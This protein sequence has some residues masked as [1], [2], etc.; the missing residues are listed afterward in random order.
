MNSGV[1]IAILDDVVKFLFRCKKGLNPA[2]GLIGI[3]ENITSN[4]ENIFDEEDSSYTRCLPSILTLVK[5]AGL[6]VIQQQDQTDFPDSIY[7]VKM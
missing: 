6:T 5:K 1:L 3:K 4:C 2:G 7:A